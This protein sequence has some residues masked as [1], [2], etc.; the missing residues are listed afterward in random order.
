MKFDE[1]ILEMELYK[2]VCR[3]EWRK[4]DECKSIEYVR[5]ATIYFPWGEGGL[6]KVEEK[7]EPFFLLALGKEELTFV[8]WMPS[9]ADRLADDWEVIEP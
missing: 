9:D 5:N 8:P 1:A 7:L 2:R 4:N 3:K 6:L